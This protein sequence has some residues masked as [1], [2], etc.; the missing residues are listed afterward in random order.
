MGFSR[1]AYW[2][3]VPPPSPNGFSLEAEKK[4]S[5]SELRESKMRKGAANRG[6]SLTRLLQMEAKNLGRS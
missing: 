3:G 2:S 5:Q 1:H 6:N 4:P